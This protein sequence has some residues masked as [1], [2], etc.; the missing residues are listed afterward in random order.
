MSKINT[1]VGSD[2]N[3]HFTNSA[4]ADSVLPFS[5]GATVSLLGTISGVRTSTY[6]VPS[7]TTTSNIYVV[8]DTVS[9]SARGDGAWSGVS[10]SKSGALYTKSISGTTLTVKTV[11]ISGSA[12]TGTSGQQGWAQTS[13]SVSPSNTSVYLII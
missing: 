12:S 11:S 10:A 2:G 5:K 1:Y 8:I 4:G 13:V 3:I 7:G 9:G 6:S